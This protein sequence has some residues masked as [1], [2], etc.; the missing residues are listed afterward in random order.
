[1]TNKLRALLQDLRVDGGRPEPLA[2]RSGVRCSEGGAV[3]M[4]R[5]RGR[6]EGEGSQI[7]LRAVVALGT[8]AGE[9][10]SPVPPSNK[11]KE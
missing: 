10:R 6:T 7:E 1:M 3:S 11:R 8:K 9:W 4:V 2:R 5:P